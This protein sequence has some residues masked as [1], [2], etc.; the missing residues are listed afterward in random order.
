[1]QKAFFLNYS[2][3]IISLGNFSRST[4]CRRQLAARMPTPPRCILPALHEPGPR[5]AACPPA[6]KKIGLNNHTAF[7]EGPVRNSVVK[8]INRRVI[9]ADETTA[10]AVDTLRQNIKLVTCQLAA[11]S[12]DEGIFIEHRKI[13]M[14]AL[15]TR[16]LLHRTRSQ[17][18]RVAF[19]DLRLRRRYRSISSTSFDLTSAR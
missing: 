13:E 4:M 14:S 8:H 3:K 16:H 9:E 7:L 19:C 12:F 15:I 11:V 5:S 2:V 6:V 18:A 17:R 10:K 1:M